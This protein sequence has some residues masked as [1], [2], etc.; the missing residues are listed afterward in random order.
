M[1]VF[2]YLKSGI[3]K[4]VSMTLRKLMYLW[5]MQ[6]IIFAPLFCFSKNILVTKRSRVY[7]TSG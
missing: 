6:T 2:D 3:V 1:L 5:I 4:Q 7:M